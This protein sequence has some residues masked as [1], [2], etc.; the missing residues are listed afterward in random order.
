MSIA[1]APASIGQLGLERVAGGE[2]AG[3]R[4]RTLVVSASPLER[5]KEQALDPRQLRLEVSLLIGALEAC[6]CA[7]GAAGEELAGKAQDDP[8]VRVGEEGAAVL[9]HPVAA[10]A[11]IADEG[12]PLDVASAAQ[13]ANGVL[14]RPLRA[15]GGGDEA[16][17]ELAVAKQLGAGEEPEGLEEVDL[18]VSVLA[19]HCTL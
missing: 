9:A 3:A 7:R 1:A 17:D 16:G 6:A 8:A 4:R 14:A 13:D 5:D 18:L 11:P 10:R 2:R 12:A 15:A 19:C